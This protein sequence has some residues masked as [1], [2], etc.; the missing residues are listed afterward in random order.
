MNLKVYMSHLEVI[1][2][3]KYLK[4]AKYYL[5]YGSG[6]ST[7]FAINNNVKNIISIETDIEWYNKLMNNKTIKNKINKNELDLIYHDLNCIW[8]KYV[9]WNKNKLIIDENNIQK[10]KA[11]SNL[12][13]KLENIP[14][15]VLIDGRFRV[16]TLLKLYHKINNNTKILFHD[17]TN[18]KQYYI[19]E[20][21]Y[22]KIE[23]VDK[24]QVFIKKLIIDQKLLDET[25][26][27][28]ELII[29]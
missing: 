28:Y 27:K 13:T 22:D 3:K 16:A 9:S 26:N 20:L 25:I 21:F 7:I 18:R 2:F 15:L 6:D 12:P 5:E 11:C 8:W 23:V 4:N 19:I 17:Y 24:L 29:D 1:L 14:D 10:W